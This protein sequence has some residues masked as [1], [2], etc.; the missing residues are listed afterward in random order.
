MAEIKEKIKNMWSAITFPDGLDEEFDRKCDNAFLKQLDRL[1]L[2][3]YS[4]LFVFSLISLYFF[5]ITEL[6]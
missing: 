5:I 4:I 2:F 3:S 1:V 6:M